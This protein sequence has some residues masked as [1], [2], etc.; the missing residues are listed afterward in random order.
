M[1]RT[2]SI[3]LGLMFFCSGFWVDAID[4]KG[5]QVLTISEAE[6]GTYRRTARRTARRTSRR[7][8]ARHNTYHYHRPYVGGAAVAATATAIA[9]GTIVATLP[10]SCN[11]V[12]VYGRI[13]YDCSD[14]WYEPR[15]DGPD[16]VY[17]VV[18]NPN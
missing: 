6:A 15:Y 4:V 10:P 9:V 1:K 13:Y 5:P 3:L 7:T 2:L 16:V 8:T 18:E 12:T 14:T 11:R 17:V